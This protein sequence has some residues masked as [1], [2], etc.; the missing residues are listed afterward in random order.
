MPK[1]NTTY[2]HNEMPEVSRVRIV[3]TACGTN[4]SVVQAAAA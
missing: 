1:V 2:I 3:F 4:D